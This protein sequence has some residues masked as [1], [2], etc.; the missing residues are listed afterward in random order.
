MR[1]SSNAE[2]SICAM[3]QIVMHLDAFLHRGFGELF[4]GGVL[5]VVLGKARG[6]WRRNKNHRWPI[7]RSFIH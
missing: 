6:V 2:P 7:P 5:G 1:C 4:F 3:T